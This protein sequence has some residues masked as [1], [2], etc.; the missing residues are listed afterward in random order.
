MAGVSAQDLGWGGPGLSRTTRVDCRGIPLNVRPEVTVLFVELVRWLTAERRR[1]NLPPLA[2][3]GGY[4]KR[5]VRGSTSTWSNHSW[6]LAADFNAATNPMTDSL[7]TDMPPGTSAKAKSLG[8]RWGGDYTGRKDPMHFEVVVSP[9]EVR[10]IVERLRTLTLGDR[11]LEVSEAGPD[12][13]ALQRLLPGVTADGDFGP[14]TW[15]AV[16]SFQRAGGLTPDGVV[17]PTTLSALL[18][19][20]PKPAP[21]HLG[22]TTMPARPPV[23]IPKKGTAMLIVFDAAMHGQYICTDSTARRIN[24]EEAEVYRAGGVPVVGAEVSA[25][26]RVLFLAGLGVKP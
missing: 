14:A 7:R 20:S 23:P 3:S 24:G 16:V 10:R 25:A 18:R 6:G 21:V 11:L 5:Y 2:S 9:A 8:M 12:V 15:A 17:G 4:I 1:L 19:V 26:T 22:G 13:A